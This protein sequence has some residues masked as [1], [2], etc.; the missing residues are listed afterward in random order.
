LDDVSILDTSANQL[1]LNGGFE[2]TA[3]GN[4]N[5]QPN[6]ANWA[7]SKNGCSCCGGIW[8]SQKKSGSYSWGD[9]CGGSTDKLSQSFSTIIGNT[10]FIS[11]W[12]MSDG[13]SPGSFYA[14][15]S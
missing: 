15:I 7:F 14:S 2:T 12:L 3:S 8:N 10:Y 11:W 4:A 9:G 6:A 13:G 1:I 5:G